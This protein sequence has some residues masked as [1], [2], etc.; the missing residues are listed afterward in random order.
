MHRAAWS[1]SVTIAKTFSLGDA[2]VKTPS[3]GNIEDLPCNN[4]KR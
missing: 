2:T 4:I 3:K 1:G